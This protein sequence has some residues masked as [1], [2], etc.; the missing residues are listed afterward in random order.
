MSS[1]GRGN[2]A[3]NGIGRH[4]KPAPAVVMVSA[5]IALNKK[6]LQGIF[7]TGRILEARSSAPGSA[8]GT[9]GSPVPRPGPFC[10]LRTSPTA[11]CRFAT[12][13]PFPLTSASSRRIVP[14][15]PHA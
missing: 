6:R 5:G 7:K 9:A 4:I 13:R 3:G 10:G 14:A 1:K 12:S 15:E 2:G 8:D 11:G